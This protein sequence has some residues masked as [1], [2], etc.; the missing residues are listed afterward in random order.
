MGNNR[1]AERATNHGRCIRT[2]EQKFNLLLAQREQHL[3]RVCRPRPA[4]LSRPRRLP[5]VATS[6]RHA[7]PAW[8]PG[9]HL[10]SP[11]WPADGRGW[12]DLLQAYCN[13][14]IFPVVDKREITGARGGFGLGN[15]FARH[16]CS[17][18]RENSDG[19]SLTGLNSC[20]SSQIGTENQNQQQENPVF[21]TNA[22]F[23]K[24]PPVTRCQKHIF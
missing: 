4:L 23:L 17:W 9:G 16:S 18:I 3:D 14:T 13:S 2:H 8:C 1:L 20:E 7:L 11:G 10:R 15:G 21:R 24:K 6:S 5:P 12:Y 22:A 19:L